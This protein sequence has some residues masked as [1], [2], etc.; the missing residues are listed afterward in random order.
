M[1]AWWSLSRHRHERLL[2]MS[3]GPRSGECYCRRRSK[4]RARRRPRC[5][6]QPV[7]LLRRRCR[8]C[9]RWRP[10][11]HRPVRSALST[12]AFMTRSPR[13]RTFTLL[14]LLHG[15]LRTARKLP[16]FCCC[17]CACREGQSRNSSP[18]QRPS[19]SGQARVSDLLARLCSSFQGRTRMHRPKRE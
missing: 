19:Q 16:D 10:Q 7:P 3:A 1:F 8:T 11:T 4:A 5:R 6:L 12:G 2:W 9:Q 15:A 14:L 13:L 18:A 17:A